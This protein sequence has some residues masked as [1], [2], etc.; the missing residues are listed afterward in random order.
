MSN[1]AAANTNVARNAISMLD[2]IAADA[3]AW[4][5]GAYK[6][7]NDEL[8]AILARCLNIFQQLKGREKARVDQRKELD[9]RLVALNITVRE[10]TNLATKIVRYVF[11]TSKKR[12]LTYARVI[13]SADEH[14]Q[15][16]VSLA[17][18]IR[19]NSGIEELRRKP[20]GE[21]TATELKQKYAA[22][23]EQYL[24]GAKALVA[25]FKADA[26]LKSS[27]ESTSVFTVALIRND[28]DGN[29]SVVYGDNNQ[30]LVKQMLARAGKKLTEKRKIKSVVVAE[31]SRKA[32]R[33]AAIGK[34]A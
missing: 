22:A 28:P 13:M 11:R 26:S 7:S 5:Q 16:A 3:K 2:R 31:R 21:F 9:E 15:D 27:A 24:H 25:P 18:W 1:T 32:N 30:T 6:T 34:A 17:K 33:A 12:T 4:E 29:V 14:K 20:K 19:D 10:N 8:Y 23:A